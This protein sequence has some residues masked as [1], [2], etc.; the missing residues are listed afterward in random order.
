MG[1]KVFAHANGAE[2]IKLAVKAG[3]ASIEHGCLLDADGIQLMKDKG[4]YL[5]A[6]IY[7]DE[8]IMAE[9]AK[10]GFPEKIMNKERKLGQIQRENFQKAVTAGVK[11][12][13][14]TDAGVYPHGWNGKQFYYIVKFG[15]TPMQ[16]I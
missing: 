14:G 1:K 12:A 9:Y 2:S 15:L 13:F 7:D 10:R 5:V 16:A 6:D 4:V 3:V 8:Y 11:I